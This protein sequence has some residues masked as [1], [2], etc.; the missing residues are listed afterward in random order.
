MITPAFDNG[1]QVRFTPLGVEEQAVS[2]TAVGLPNMPDAEKVRRVVIRPLNADIVYSDDGS[3]P[4]A[5]HGI[6]VLENEVLVYDGTK[7]SDFKMI[8]RA[9]VDADVR[10]AYYGL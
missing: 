4:T 10:V 8:R 1:V 9:A 6:P 3:D 5:G 2:S 7:I